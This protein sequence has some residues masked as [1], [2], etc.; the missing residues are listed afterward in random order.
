VN[1]KDEIIEIQGTAEHAPLP[2]EE[3]VKMVEIGLH[4]I[5]EIRTIQK[6][7]LDMA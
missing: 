3:M 5:G 7:I 6:N 2:L 4:G 1:E